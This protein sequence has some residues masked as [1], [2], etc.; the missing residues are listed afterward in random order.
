MAQGNQTQSNSIDWPQGFDQNYFE[1][2]YHF[3]DYTDRMRVIAND[4]RAAM[5]Y[6]NMMDELPVAS[7]KRNQ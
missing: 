5:H 2:T 3:P 6:L 7:I 4:T 1:Y